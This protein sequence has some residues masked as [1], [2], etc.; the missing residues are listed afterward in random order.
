VIVKT[1]ISIFF[2]LFIQGAWGQDFEEIDSFLSFLESGQE[3]VQAINKAIQN[4]C[5]TR[6]NLGVGGE[7]CI[8]ATQEV[9]HCSSSLDQASYCFDGVVVL[10]EGHGANELM[11][12]YLCTDA[13]LPKPGPEYFRF[14]SCLKPNLAEFD[15]NILRVDAEISCICQERDNQNLGWTCFDLTVE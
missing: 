15:K 13:T 3:E 5:Q 6:Q 11:M 2:I 12:E 7:S 4:R 1:F 10:N 8:M 9:A 14:G